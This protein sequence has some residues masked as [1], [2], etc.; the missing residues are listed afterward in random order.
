M[1]FNFGTFGLAPAAFIIV[2]SVARTARLIVWDDF[3]PM[4][5]LRPRLIAWFG[6]K[7]GKL[8]TCQ[9]CLTPY[10]TAGIILWAWL[11][12]LHWTWWVINGVWG[13]SYVAA[14]IVAYDQPE[15]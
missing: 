13:L 7:W 2:L 12:D 5:W 4:M 6:E 14:I 3:P 10:L 1:L 11:C 9:F 15:E 8:W